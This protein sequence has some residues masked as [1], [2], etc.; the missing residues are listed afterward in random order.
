MHESDKPTEPAANQRTHTDLADPTAGREGP[1]TPSGHGPESAGQ[2]LEPR[3]EHDS[4]S[5]EQVIERAKSLG[6]EG[7]DAM[8]SDQLL[9]AIR[10]KEDPERVDATRAADQTNPESRRDAPPEAL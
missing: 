6:I 4:L 10:R 5:E 9:E 7:Y 2:D 8:L 3:F 1:A